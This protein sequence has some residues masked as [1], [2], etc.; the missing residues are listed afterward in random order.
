MLGLI[1]RAFQFFLRD[2]YGVPQWEL[3]AKRAE[4]SVIGFESM[5]SYHAA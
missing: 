4:F 5:L 2:T 1:P 3:V